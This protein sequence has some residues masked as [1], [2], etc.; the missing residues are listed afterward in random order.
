MLARRDILNMHVAGLAFLTQAA[1]AE[2]LSEADISQLAG[3]DL[4]HLQSHSCTL[5][6]GLHAHTHRLHLQHQYRHLKVRNAHKKSN[7][8][9]A[10]AQ[11]VRAGFQSFTF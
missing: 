6:H 11:L 10:D 1:V 8:E 9:A 4:A 2:V 5:A 7:K 3:C